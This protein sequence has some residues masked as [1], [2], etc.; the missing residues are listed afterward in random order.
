MSTLIWIAVAGIP[1]LGVLAAGNWL[2]RRQ[3]RSDTVARWK[4]IAGGVLLFLG[5]VMALVVAVGALFM[6][7][8]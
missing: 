8:G 2:L 6:V 3:V 5:I 7:P 1:T 4:V